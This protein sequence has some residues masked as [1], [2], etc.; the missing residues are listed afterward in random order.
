MPSRAT[1][2]RVCRGIG[3]APDPFDQPSRCA[4]SGIG[5]RGNAGLQLPRGDRYDTGMGCRGR[6]PCAEAGRHGTAVSR[7]FSPMSCPLTRSLA[8][9]LGLRVSETIA[10]SAIRPRSCSFATAMAPP[11]NPA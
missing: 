9:M 8:A 2:C 3:E 10:I 5:T 6:L 4:L 11:Y 1:I 7:R